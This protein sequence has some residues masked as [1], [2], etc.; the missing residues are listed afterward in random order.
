MTTF[1]K[2][3]LFLELRNVKTIDLAHKAVNC[4]EKT[5]WILM[6]VI[7]AAWAVWFI[8]FSWDDGA[9]ILI[10]GNSEKLELKHPAFT[11]CPKVSSKY[12]FA[13]KLGNLIDPMN[14]PEELL[15]LRHDFFLCAAGFSKK[16]RGSDSLSSYKEL[17]EW[18]CNY[19]EQ[20]GCEVLNNEYSFDC[21]YNNFT[22]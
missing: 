21:S 9:S 7:G 15:T 20:F 8:S 14:L 3:V 13:E 5:L 12:A 11:I 10:Q 1:Y 22:F 4:L 17:Y 19:M 2:E 6:G 16:L 18:K